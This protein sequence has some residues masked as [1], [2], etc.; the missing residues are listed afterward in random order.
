M[1]HGPSVL[2]SWDCKSLSVLDLALSSS[3]CGHGFKD[4]RLNS[5]TCQEP[6]RSDPWEIQVLRIGLKSSYSALTS[7]RN[8]RG[9]RG[10]SWA[11]DLPYF[12]RIFS[13][14]FFCLMLYWT[15]GLRPRPAVRRRDVLCRQPLDPQPA[16]VHAD[17]KFGR[18]VPSFES[19]SEYV[20]GGAVGPELAGHKETGIYCT[21]RHVA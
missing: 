15:P 16:N 12:W 10:S 17:G 8:L 19:P 4:P 20:T 3:V 9:A 1:C 2:R 14:N 21:V 13:I 7:Y 5:E 18:G 11:P 6:V